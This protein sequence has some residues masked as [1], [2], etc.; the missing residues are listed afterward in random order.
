MSSLQLLLF[1]LRLLKNE[2]VHSQPEIGEVFKE[3]ALPLLN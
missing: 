1:T 3:W 2:P